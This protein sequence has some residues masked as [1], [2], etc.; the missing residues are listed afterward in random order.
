MNLTIADENAFI[1]PINGVLRTKDYG[2]HPVGIKYRSPND[3]AR[4]KLENGREAMSIAH[5]ICA[6]F[7]LPDNPMPKIFDTLDRRENNTFEQR[8]RI[9]EKVKTSIFAYTLDT[10]V[11]PGYRSAAISHY[12][13]ITS[14]NPRVHGLEISQIM[15][16]LHPERAGETAIAH[17]R[18]V[19]V[20]IHAIRSAVMRCGIRT[21]DD[22]IDELEKI[23]PW[24]VLACEFGR[25]GVFPVLTEHG[26]YWCEYN[27]SLEDRIED[28]RG[29]ENVAR[30]IT[31]I[32]HDEMNT[33]TKGVFHT[34]ME[35]G[36]FDDVPGFPSLLPM[37]SKQYIIMSYGFAAGD[38]WK[39]RRNHSI[40][41]DAQRAAVSPQEEAVYS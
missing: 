38:A 3:E 21:A 36:F 33:F 1:C 16:D 41:R 19:H 10:A 39:S 37:S 8:K 11:S 40:R 13:Q 14:N 17:R 12:A 7:P 24:C 18:R 34:M 32:S 29:G 6:A 20:D 9:C 15:L 26:V 27:R 31:F 2:G 28:I 25:T 4:V 35:A 30:V 23:L 5:E 22:F